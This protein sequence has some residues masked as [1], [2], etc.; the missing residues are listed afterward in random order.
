LDADHPKMRVNFAC[1]STAERRLQ[2]LGRA[3]RL[4]QRVCATLIAA[5]HRISQ[6]LPAFEWRTRAF[7]QIPRGTAIRVGRG[8]FSIGRLGEPKIGRGER[9][10]LEGPVEGR[11]RGGGCGAR[12]PERF[13]PLVDPAD[14]VLIRETTPF[15]IA[16]TPSIRLLA[17]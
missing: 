5:L 11:L 4:G 12:C 3:G 13:Q 1:R 15:S 16:S 9:I 17:A 6:R 10:V 14:E 7:G 2:P 8:Q